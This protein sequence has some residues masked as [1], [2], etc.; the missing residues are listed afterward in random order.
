[1]FRLTFGATE[2]ATIKYALLRTAAYS[3]WMAKDLE[4]RLEGGEDDTDLHSLIETYRRDAD[5]EML[6]TETI[7]ERA[8]LLDT[9]EDK[10]NDA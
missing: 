8:E 6:L 2:L 4:A 5:D 9:K 3:R 1:M 7:F 10:R